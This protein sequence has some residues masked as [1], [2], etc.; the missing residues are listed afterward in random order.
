MNNVSKCEFKHGS[1]EID[2]RIY[3]LNAIGMLPDRENLESYNKEFY[4][5]LAEIKIIDLPIEKEKR[6]FY[7]FETN[8]NAC[9]TSS[10][11]QIAVKL[12]LI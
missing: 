6:L 5:N 12:I 2:N 1:N 11:S 8:E 7:H 9:I 3:E 4:K 10:I